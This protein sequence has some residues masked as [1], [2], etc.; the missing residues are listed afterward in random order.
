MS[1]F[2]LVAD[3][4]GTHVR[5][6]IVDIASGKPAVSSVRI[7][8]TRDHADIAAAAKA[9]LRE[10]GKG[11]PEALVFAVAGP[12]N[13]NSVLLTNAGWTI[14]GN[15]LQRGLGVEHALVVN[16]FEAIAHAVPHF[17]PHDLVPVGEGPVFDPQSDGTIAIVGPGT[18]LGVGGAVRKGGTTTALVSEGGHA[19]FAPLNDIEIRILQILARKFGRVSNERI[20]SGPGLLNLYQAMAEIEGATAKDN[21]PEA[22]TTAAQENPI[23]FEGKVFARF[24][25]ILGSAAGDLAL[26]FGA[27][28]GVLLGGGIL[29]DALPFLKASDFRKRFEDKARFKDYVA[30]IPTCV[31]VQEHAGLIGAAAIL[32]NHVGQ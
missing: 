3:I 27:R 26:I 6:A 22:I 8:A 32:L 13:N 30:S 4:G 28:K 25:A 29:P 9:Y 7:Y 21:T 12:V 2:G 15:G 11:M 18:G 16:D 10:T 20:L 19:A 31:I 24:C 1:A 17:G 14:S 23:S 5:F